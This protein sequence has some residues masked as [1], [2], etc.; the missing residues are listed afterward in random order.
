MKNL[1]NIRSG[2]LYPDYYLKAGLPEYGERMLPRI[3]A[4]L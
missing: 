1:Y 2:S 4:L 3:F